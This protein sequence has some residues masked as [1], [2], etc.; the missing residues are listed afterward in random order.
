MAENIQIKINAA[1]E[2][3]QAAK[4]IGDLKRSLVE[5]Q[6]IAEENELGADQFKALQ[7]QIVQ[8]NT[9]LANAKDRIGDIQDSLSTLQGTPVERLSTSF[10][11]LKQSIFNLDFQK[12]TIGVKGLVDAFTPL[13]PD[14]APLK[15]LAA[16]RGTLGGL[17]QGVTALGG[18]FAQ[19]GKALL[20]N[21]LFLLGAAV[22]AIVAAISTLLNSLG[23]LRPLLD[24]IGKITEGITDAFN[25]LTEAIGLN[26]NATDK[27][28][29]AV[30][31]L[32]KGR[33]D[34]IQSTLD[35]SERIAAATAEL[36]S[37]E[38]KQ[39]EKITGLYAGQAK[40]IETTRLE[41]LGRLLVSLNDEKRAYENV[42]QNKRNLTEEEKKS[43]DEIVKKIQDTNVKIIELTADRVQRTNEALEAEARR[44]IEFI[45]NGYERAR[46][47]RELDIKDANAQ[48]D[49][50]AK[51]LQEQQ[52]LE[53]QAT[54][55]KINLK[56][57]E[58]ERLRNIIAQNALEIKAITDKVANDRGAAER[59]YNQEITKLNA[60]AAAKRKASEDEKKKAIIDNLRDLIIA[61]E[62]AN[63][64]I[65]DNATLSSQRRLEAQTK[66]EN[67]RLDLLLKIADVEKK[68][69]NEK[70]K[71]RLETLD[72]IRVAQKKFDEEQKTEA[73]KRADL[74]KAVSELQKEAASGRLDVLKA[75]LQAELSLLDTK[76]EAAKD[77]A[78]R[79]A[80]EKEQLALRKQIASITDE[81]IQKEIDSQRLLLETRLTAA[82][83]IKNN[84][85]KVNDDVLKSTEK[86]Q[87]L[88]KDITTKGVSDLASIDAANKEDKIKNID[89]VKQAE[90]ALLQFNF[91]NE[92]IKRAE[93]FKTSGFIT[94]LQSVDL[95]LTKKFNAE[96]LAIIK[97]SAIQEQQIAKLTED[98]KIALVR[99]GISAIAEVSN[100]LFDIAQNNGK[101]SLAQEEKIAKQKFAV[102]KALQVS[103]AIIDGFKAVTTSLAQSP[104]AIGPVPNPAGIA[105]LAFA[106]T[107]SL[108]NIGKILA[109]QYKSTS[110]APSGG[111]PNIPTANEGGAEP[112]AR[113]FTAPTFFGLGQGTFTTD[114]GP[115]QNRVYVLETD[116]TSV[117]NRVSVIESRSVLE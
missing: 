99:N 113:E 15:G 23:I 66:F 101:K 51:I 33:Q 48:L 5:L 110:G 84:N 75:L 80:I 112:A 65:Q 18:S 1:V 50:R 44:S 115:N 102:N 25:D 36:G 20:T 114:L 85:L 88:I 39:I 67:N 77:D 95:E 117:Q 70:E 42:A 71:L 107:T 62:N 116:I 111:N 29:K 90:L 104:V 94:N 6:T 56:F 30:V 10:G 16:L 52:G 12:A 43:Y 69:E 89:A 13:G 58:E 57:K 37:K 79:V 63:K 93:L 59:K 17:G 74:E 73:Q 86:T 11:L 47:T 109:T 60:D 105:S 28:L 7:T 40:T 53:E 24:A 103:L 82:N 21:P 72:R 46:L 41:L 4:T 64:K 19:L 14:G 100:L 98:E 83:L 9:E 106:I 92:A 108:A 91:E 68:S 87:Q 81:Q 34:A 22:I 55:A 76:K 27:N 31:A 54:Q 49:K 35:A 45:D 8:T 61:E 3:A 38:E 78:E 26:T 2:S 32:E 97:S 96:K